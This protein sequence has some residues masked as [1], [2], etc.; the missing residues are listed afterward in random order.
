M[1]SFNDFFESLN[2]VFSPALNPFMAYAASD[3]NIEDAVI[4]AEIPNTKEL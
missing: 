1:N 4:T 2:E 3:D